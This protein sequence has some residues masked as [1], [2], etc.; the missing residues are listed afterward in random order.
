MYDKEKI[1]IMSKL[2]VY[3]KN[4]FDRDAKAGQY[5]RHDYIYKHNMR[6]RFFLGIGC[7]IL[8]LFYVMHLL[9]I[10][11]VDIFTLDFEVEIM[12]LLFYGLIIMLAYSF[13]GTIIYTRDFI[14]SERRVNA[15]FALMRQ[16]NGEASDE[17]V[18]I[19]QK[20][21]KVHK[22]KIKATETTEADFEEHVPYRRY[23]RPTLEYRRRSN[24]NTELREDDDTAK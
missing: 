22:K 24:L 7:V 21:P 10:E 6:M 19:M 9:A 1:Q 18:A 17:D 2:A 5:F 23:E 16:L 15:Y 13:I 3:D 12:R 8:L 4:D 14:K 20:K 11:G